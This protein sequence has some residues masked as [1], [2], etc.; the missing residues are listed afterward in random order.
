VLARLQ[1]AALADEQGSALAL[2]LV[3]LG[4]AAARVAPPAAAIEHA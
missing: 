4:A 2:E 3:G 1:A